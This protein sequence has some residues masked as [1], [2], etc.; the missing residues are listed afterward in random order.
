MGLFS[1][2]KNALAPS[3][4]IQRS[5]SNTARGAGGAV[6]SV[7]ECQGKLDALADNGVYPV[8]HAFS[9]VGVA[10]HSHIIIMTRDGQDALFNFGLFDDNGSAWIRLRDGLDERWAKETSGTYEPNPIA[11]T[12]PQI[13]AAFDAATQACGGK[14][15]LLHNNCQKFAR[16]FMTALGSQHNR[17]LFRL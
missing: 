7:F 11:A 9:K 2:I 14:Y 10:H 3:E 5:K 16:E 8:M 17:S 4:P 12:K 1:R 13:L 6:A 15:K